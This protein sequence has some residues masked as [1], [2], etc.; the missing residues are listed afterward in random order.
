MI[1][2]VSANFHIGITFEWGVL[3]VKEELMDKVACSSFVYTQYRCQ[4][5]KRVI[6]S[7]HVYWV[8]LLE[9]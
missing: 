6:W 4:V 5:R 8:K 2:V 3:R 7:K 9:S 1:C